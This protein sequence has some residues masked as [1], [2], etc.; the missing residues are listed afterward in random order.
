[1]PRRRAPMATVTTGWGAGFGSRVGCCCGPPGEQ[2]QDVLR[3]K[4]RAR[5]DRVAAAQTMLVGSEKPQRLDQMEMLFGTGHSDIKEAALFVDLR[6][7]VGGHVGGDA[8][9]D[10]VQ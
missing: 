8:A 6:W 1:M 3:Q 10:E 5:R 2:R 7:R 4:P 9:I